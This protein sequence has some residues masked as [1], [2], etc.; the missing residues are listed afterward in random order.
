[1][2]HGGK[3]ISMAPQPSDVEWL[4]VEKLLAKALA[5]RSA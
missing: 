5:S 2:N 4:A 1:L 3:E